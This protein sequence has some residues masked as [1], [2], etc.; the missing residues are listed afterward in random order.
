MSQF[1]IIHADDALRYL[2]ARQLEN[3]SVTLDDIRRTAGTGDAMS[4]APLQDLRTK[5]LLLKKKFPEKLTKRDPQGGRFE[6]EAC[7]IVHAGLANVD[8]RVRADHDFWTWLAVDLLADIVEWRFGTA[9]RPAQNANYGIGT[10]AENM[11]FRLWLRADLGKTPGTEPY[12]LAKMGDQDLWRSHLLRQG[13]ANARSIVR[14]LLKLQAGKLTTQNKTAKKLAGGEDPNG[15]R[16]LA[17]R[18]RRMRANVVFEY[19]STEQADALV[20]EL[21]LDLKKGK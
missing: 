21:S 10:R 16:M 5:L 6:S 8:R 11:F 18:L 17:K 4:N 15:V 14:A 2:K 19:L 20:Y 9:G 7:G 13:Y 1:P 12:A 3:D